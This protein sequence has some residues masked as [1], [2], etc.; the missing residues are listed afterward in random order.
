MKSLSTLDY[1]TVSGHLL[2]AFSAGLGALL[3]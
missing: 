1:L 2:L 3:L